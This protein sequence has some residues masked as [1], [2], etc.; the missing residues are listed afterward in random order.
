LKFRGFEEMMR[1]VQRGDLSWQR[2]GG[3]PSARHRHYQAELQ[4]LDRKVATPLSGT[5]IDLSF[6]R[7]QTES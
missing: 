3:Q 7:S 5:V 6:K 2:R 1:A 4:F